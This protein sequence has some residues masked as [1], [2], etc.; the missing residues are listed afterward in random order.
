M[1]AE[2]EPELSHVGDSQPDSFWTLFTV[3]DTLQFPF[4][5]GS[6]RCVSRLTPAPPDAAF[7][8]ATGG[9]AALLFPPNSAMVTLAGVQ[10]CWK[11]RGSGRDGA[12][13]GRAIV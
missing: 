12:A 7:Q 5:T 13:H 4:D 8:P 9:P 11:L 1:E 6:P 2:S 3:S 10:T